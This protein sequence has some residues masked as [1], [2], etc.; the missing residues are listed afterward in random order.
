MSVQLEPYDV[1]TF[2]RPLTRTTKETLN[3]T[4]PNA[5]DIAFKVKTT[6]PKLYCVRPNAGVV[7][8]GQSLEVQVMLQPFKEEPPLDQK[9][10]DKFLVQT[11]P[12][13]YDWK[14]LE[15]A[16]LW[17]HVES[18]AK[19]KIQQIKLRC[20]YVGENEDKVSADL[21]VDSLAAESDLKRDSVSATTGVSPVVDDVARLRSE[22]DLYKNELQ[23]LRERAPP[24]VDGTLTKKNGISLP[25]VA[26]I[27]LIAFLVP[28]VIFRQ[29]A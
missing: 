2:K 10:K 29:S 9:C 17:S 24:A 6:A 14:S 23:A 7:P 15:L 27:A 21:N 16:D 11:V 1:L 25:I 28:F 12:M 8:A 4:N 13:E 18:N 3:I 26:A 5:H 19:N 22:L 20:N